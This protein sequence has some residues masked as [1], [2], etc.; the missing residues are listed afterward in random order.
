MRAGTC[1][2]RCGREELDPG[3][4]RDDI[5]QAGFAG[6]SDINFEGVRRKAGAVKDRR[7]SKRRGTGSKDARIRD[8]FSGRNVDV[9]NAKPAQMVQ[10]EQVYL[11][12]PPSWHRKMPA[13]P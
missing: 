5:R 2:S 9:L 6:P 8:G 12:R 4:R 7:R 10:P 3:F 11:E 1:V 13:D